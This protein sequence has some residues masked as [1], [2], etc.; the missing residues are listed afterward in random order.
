M[1]RNIPVPVR[2]ILVVSMCC[3]MAFL[4]AT[5][6]CQAQSLVSTF[7]SLAPV[8]SVERYIGPILPPSGFGSTFRS[9]VGAG[10][11]ITST[12]KAFLKGSANGE[13]DLKGHMGLD[14]GPFRYD[15]YGN[16]RLWRFGLRGEYTFFDNKTVH[17]TRGG[18]DLTGL[19]VGGDFDVVQ[20]NW[21]TLGAALDAS[22]MK[23]T[24]RARLSSQDLLVEMKGAKPVTLGAYL[25]HVPP[26]IL[27]FPMHVEAFYKAPISGSKLTSY[28][29]AL[30][31]RPQM[32]RF[33]VSIKLMAQ[34]VKL[35]FSGAPDVNLGTLAI[36]QT[37]ELDAFWRF[38]G[39]EAAVLF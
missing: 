28:G 36:P 34:D 18:I 12:E 17:P 2:N 23:P 37:Y 6:P 10:L 9:E 39:M 14:D 21:L 24:L 32:Y 11:F 4:W 33:D 25:R 31:M 16:L 22:L 30:C 5:R 3:A 20:L 27:G 35:F 7:S 1:T 13:L 29:V 38:Y 8:K 19:K 15:A 26:D